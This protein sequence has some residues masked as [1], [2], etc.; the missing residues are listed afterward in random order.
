MQLIAHYFGGIVAKG[1]TKEYGY[2]VINQN[3][4]DNLILNGMDNQINVW[5][6]HGDRIDKLPV[7]FRSIAYTENSPVAVM[8]EVEPSTALVVVSACPDTRV[9]VLP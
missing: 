6:S 2:A 8:V 9:F 5:M 1:Y 4:V 3:G 7:G